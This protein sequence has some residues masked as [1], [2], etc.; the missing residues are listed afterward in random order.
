MALVFDV[1]KLHIYIL[2]IYLYFISIL[3]YIYVIFIFWGWGIAVFLV[4]QDQAEVSTCLP[5]VDGCRQPVLK[6]SFHEA[7]PPIVD[8]KPNPRTPLKWSPAWILPSWGHRHRF[9]RC[10]AP[11]M[12]TPLRGHPSAAPSAATSGHSQ[13]F[14]SGMRPFSEEDTDL[15]LARG[16]RR[17][18][19]DAVKQQ[20]VGREVI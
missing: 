1:A 5:W 14:R 18:Q 10:H 17:R 6:C 7:P 15:R 12:A 8:T 9:C 11:R 2:G 19:R 4:F 20:P 16:G 3:G 13:R